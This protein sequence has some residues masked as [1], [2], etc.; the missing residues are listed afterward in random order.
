MDGSLQQ[1]L[2]LVLE[3]ASSQAPCLHL[4]DKGTKFFFLSRQVH[5]H[6]ITKTL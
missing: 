1:L 5:N 6:L 3:S 2:R 4:S